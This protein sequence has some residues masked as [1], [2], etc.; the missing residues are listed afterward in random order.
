MT[1]LQDEGMS[2]VE[3][4]DYVLDVMVPTLTVSAI[5]LMAILRAPW[6]TRM[7]LLAVLL[8]LI[9]MSIITAV[10]ML[11][12]GSYN[13]VLSPWQRVVLR[14][15]G[16]VFYGHFKMPG[17]SAAM[18]FYVHQCKEHGS[19]L[20]SVHGRSQLRCPVCDEIEVPVIGD[21]GRLTLRRVDG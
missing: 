5:F 13:G 3:C 2:L 8:G 15:S 11:W 20:S 19:V 12:H 7:D 6:K 1:V 17:W 14:I 21:D 16:S 4:I 18:P 10:V 9:S